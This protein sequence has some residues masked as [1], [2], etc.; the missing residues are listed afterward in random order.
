MAA[1]NRIAQISAG[2]THALALAADGRLWAWGNNADS[3][4]GNVNYYPPGVTPAPQLVSDLMAPVAIAAGGTHSLAINP[5][6]SIVAFGSGKG[7]GD[8][9]GTSSQTPVAS[10]GLTLA[11]NT[12]LSSDADGDGL[13]GW[14][15]YLN[16]SDPLNN[17]TNGNGIYDGVEAVGVNAPNNPDTDSDG[18]ANWVEV[19]AGTDPFNLDSDGDE[20]NDGADA[21]PLDPT[22]SSPPSGNPSDTT[23]PTITLTEPTN[24]VLVP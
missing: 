1:L 12:S 20:V 10:S 4:L 24:A 8:G 5:D 9:V 16:G 15:E 22:R 18:L 23:P 14:R 11:T 13:N 2:R 17:D 6:G 3:Q 7:L 21:F 19:Q